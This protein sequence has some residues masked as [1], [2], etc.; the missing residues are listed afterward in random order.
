M[1]VHPVLPPLLLAALGGVVLVT[2]I[3]VLPR[4]R[5]GGRVAV[6]RWCAITA[7]AVLL[8][9]AALRPTFGDEGRDA[10]RVAGD[11]DPNVFVLLDRSAEMGVRD[12]DGRTRMAAAR[13]DVAALIDRY[14][15][16]RFAVIEF[17]SRPSVLWPLSADVWSLRPVLS[18]VTADAGADVAQ[19]N[20]GAAGNVLRYQLISAQQ[21]FPRAA[22]LVYYLG[23]GAP[24]SQ[25]PQRQFDLPEGAVDGGAVLG[26]GIAAA[27]RLRAVAGQIGVPYVNRT[28]PEPLVDVLPADPAAAAGAGPAVGAPRIEIYWAPAGIAAVLILVELCL[29][30]RELR[31]ST[32]TVV[33]T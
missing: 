2:R 18:A 17:T 25:A 15:D 28:D 30:L 13:D 3:A 24:G 31:R 16:A 9:V 21:Q 29:V 7:A 22:N 5:S 19:G 12:A 4:V 6:W 11:R 32:D 8:L 10:V 27:D 20:V 14:P 1:S 33:P 26:Y 23:A